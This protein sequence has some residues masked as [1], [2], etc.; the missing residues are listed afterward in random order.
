MP[1]GIFGPYSTVLPMFAAFPAWVPKA[2]QERIASYQTYE[3]IYW[4]YIGESSRKKIAMIIL[5]YITIIVALV[6]SYLLLNQGLKLSDSKSVSREVGFKDELFVMGV[7]VAVVAL[8]IAFRKLMC[9]IAEWRKPNTRTAKAL[10][11]VSTS[12]VFHLVYYAII[13]TIYF[14]QY[15]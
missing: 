4:N 3:E 13:P 7:A 9:T 12:I 5:E 1:T 14:T 15:E 10:F 2:D 11:I 6:L 8:G